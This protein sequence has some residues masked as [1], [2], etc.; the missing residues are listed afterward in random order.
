MRRAYLFYY[1]IASLL[2]G[3]LIYLIEYLKI[4]IPSVIRSYVPDALWA[5]SFMAC[6]CWIWHDTDKPCFFWI[7]LSIFVMV[8][9]EFFQYRGWISGTADL[10]DALIYVIFSLPFIILLYK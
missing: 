7:I 10:T 8:S 2:S 6:I 5:S 4:E 3:L 1:S 9:F